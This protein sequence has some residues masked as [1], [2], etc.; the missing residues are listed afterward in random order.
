MKF[1]FEFLKHVFLTYGD[2]KK[3][4]IDLIKQAV[5]SQVYSGRWL[6]SFSMPSQTFTV[7]RGE[8]SGYKYTD[9]SEEQ[10]YES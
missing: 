2:K 5:C 1:R 8:P 10:R 7:N 9:L 4:T 6:C 3:N